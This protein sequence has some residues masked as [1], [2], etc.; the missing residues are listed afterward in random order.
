M[1]SSYSQNIFRLYIIKC[2][3]WFMLVMPIVVPFYQS[4]G[5][6]M[7][8]VFFL[9]AIYS[10]AIVL[11]EIPSGYFADVW[12]RK[13]TL[14]A[15]TIMGAVGFGIYSFSYRFGE[16][17]VA[18]MILGVGQSLISGS[19][20]ALLYDSLK[21]EKREL[22]YLK[23]E[24]RVTSIGNFAEA[25]AGVLGGLLATLSL[26][27]PYYGQTL[28][29]L[30][31]VPAALSL[32]EPPRDDRHVKPGWKDILQVVNHSLV[33]NKNLRTAILYSSVIGTATLTM[34]WFVQPFFKEISLPLSMFGVLWTVLN[35]LAGLVSMIAYKFE[36][37]LGQKRTVFLILVFI[38]GS[39]VAISQT[40][41]AWGIAILVVFYFVRGIATPVLKNYIIQY[42]TS[43]NRA[44]VLSVRSFVI[45]IIFA[46]IGPFLGWYTDQFSLGSA[47]AIAGMVFFTGG[48]IVLLPFLQNRSRIR[49]DNR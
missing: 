37:A 11:L 30:I 4:N 1:G 26:R 38:T 5:L 18:E 36:N 34:A 13:T 23:L 27:Y 33:E 35:L 14:V 32:K 3:K 46:G 24:G 41:T 7:H 40:M 44:T 49:R 21:A 15:G 12:G 22:E 6:T 31:G 48:F 28:V 16:F 42:T 17:L 43:A 20:S 47:L 2:A 25:I 19:D 39:Y 10:I 45:R 29:A 8:D 9:R